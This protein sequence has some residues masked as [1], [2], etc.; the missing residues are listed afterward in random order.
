MIRLALTLGVLILTAV[1]WLPVHA[2]AVTGGSALAQAVMIMPGKAIGP[3]QVGMSLDQARSTMQTFGEVE[4]V[5]DQGSHGFCNPEDGVGVCAF[6]RLVRLGLNT[7]GTVVYIVTDDVRFATDTG[8]LKV[9]QPL[10]EFLKAFGLYTGGQGSEV[11]WEG[12]GLAVDVR[13]TEAGMVVRYI[14]VFGPRGASAMA[15]RSL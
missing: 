14:S 5:N 8:S 9:G 15:P 12:R 1:P 13:P 2:Q 3:F 11:R 4:E 10:L 7:P 6:D